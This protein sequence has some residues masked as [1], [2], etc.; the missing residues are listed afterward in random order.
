MTTARLYP[1]ARPANA[2]TP[3]MEEAGAAAKMMIV[4]QEME[5]IV[6][7]KRIRV[8]TWAVAP[9]LQVAV[10]GGAVPVQMS[11]AVPGAAGRK[12][13]VAMASIRTTALGLWRLLQSWK[14]EQ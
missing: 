11:M 12:I 1:T 3:Q 6:V 10:K 13:P 2:V 8:Q 9:R 7:G 4:A 5:T 14:L